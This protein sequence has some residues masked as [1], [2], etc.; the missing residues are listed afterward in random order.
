MKFSILQAI[1]SV[2][3]L[4]YALPSG[5]ALDQD[6]PKKV[7]AGVEVVYTPIIADAIEY[8]RANSDNMTFNHVMRSFLFGSVQLANNATLSQVDKEVLAVGT[9]LHDLGWDE[10][11]NS[12]IVTK[13]LRFELDSAIAAR[14][15][16]RSHPDGKSWDERR[17]QLMWDGIALHTEHQIAFN[18][19][20]DVQAISLGIS[21]DFMGPSGPVTRDVYKKIVAEYP[22]NDLMQGVKQKTV[23]LCKTKPQGTYGKCSLF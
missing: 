11:P 13:D 5:E 9:L 4:A 1:A 2:L 8:V 3:P 15:F 16:I 7:I 23:W 21:H 17:V 6:V 12:K 19:E 20:L 14:K 18:K 10:S 22:Q